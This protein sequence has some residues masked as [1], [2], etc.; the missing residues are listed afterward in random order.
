M[1]LEKYCPTKSSK[2]VGAKE[3]VAKIKYWISTWGDAKQKRY[4][5]LL[6]SGPSGIGKT[7]LVK[8]IADEMGYHIISL[9]AS[10][11]RGA[12]VLKEKLVPITGNKIISFSG[13]SGIEKKK[14]MILI[15]EVDCMGASDRGGIS[16]IVSIIKKT[17][18]PIIAICNNKSDI[19]LKSLVGVCYTIE[20]YP[21][22]PNLLFRYT[23]H[24]CGKEGIIMDDI[25]SKNMVACIGTDVRQLLISLDMRSRSKDKSK[26]SI[27]NVKDTLI[28]VLL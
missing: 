21:L 12:S 14:H 5:A 16:E 6:L 10:D 25:E 26:S 11:K 7:F 2:I 9:D 18:I 1:I 8:I 3:D 24:I 13:S 15:D 4:N 19:K 17:K 28:V 23:K 22:D 27:V 20:R